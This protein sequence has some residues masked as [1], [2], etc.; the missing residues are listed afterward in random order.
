MKTNEMSHE[1]MQATNGGMSLAP[2]APQQTDAVW[3]E[4]MPQYASVAPE[5]QGFTTAAG[6]DVSPDAGG[7]Q[8]AQPRYIK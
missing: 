5:A 2:N 6:T 4:P 8:P 7:L 1:E 3:S